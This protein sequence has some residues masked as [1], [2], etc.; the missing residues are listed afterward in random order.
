MSIWVRLAAAHWGTALILCID[1]GSSA[2]LV[3]KTNWFPNLDRQRGFI[4]F[5]GLHKIVVSLIYTGELLLTVTFQKLK[6]A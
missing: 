5:S 1:L 6:T 4:F 3:R 2:D